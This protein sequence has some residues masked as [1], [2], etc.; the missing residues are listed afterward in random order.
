M[1]LGISLSILFFNELW[2]FSKGFVVSR[3]RIHSFCLDG[4]LISGGRGRQESLLL[5]S[6]KRNI[7]RSVALIDGKVHWNFSGWV[8]RRRRR[9]EGGLI[10]NWIRWALSLDYNLDKLRPITEWI[11]KGLGPLS[12]LHTFCPRSLWSY[13]FYFYWRPFRR[14][15][16]NIILYATVS[17]HIHWRIIQG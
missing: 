4:W 16:A 10:T 13:L 6:S 15:F 7:Q 5:L 9:R 8:G 12:V 14:L 11:T 3:G 17:V 1:A 2:E